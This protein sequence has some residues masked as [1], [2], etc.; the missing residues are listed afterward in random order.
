MMQGGKLGIHHP[1][2]VLVAWGLHFASLARFAPPTEVAPGEYHQWGDL[3][4]FH[5]FDD[6]DGGLMREGQAGRPWRGGGRVCCAGCPPP[7]VSPPQRQQRRRLCSPSPNNPPSKPLLP[8]H[9]ALCNLPAAGAGAGCFNKDP[10]PPIVPLPLS[11]PPEAD[12]TPNPPAHPPYIT[13]AI[14][15]LFLLLFLLL[16]LS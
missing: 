16:F 4:F 9:C 15:S 13:N 11:S 6:G 10:R 2:T 7:L 8:R 12:T 3:R 14:P 5:A 1:V